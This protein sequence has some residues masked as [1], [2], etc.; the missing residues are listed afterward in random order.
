MLD[1]AFQVLGDRWTSHIIAS[2][3]LGHRRFSAFQ[4]ALGVATNVLSDRLGRLVEMGVLT[5]QR[6]RQRPDR[7]EYRLTDEGRDLYPLIAELNRWGDRWLDGGKGPPLVTYHLAC[8]HRLEPRITCDQC[9]EV[10]N[11]FT[12]SA[13]PVAPPHAP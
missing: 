10:A 13:G 4:R 7:F 12:T 5:R 11:A 9:G 2:A 8:G 6:Y 1:R 3:F